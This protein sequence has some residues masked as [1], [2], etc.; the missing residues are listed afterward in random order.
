MCNKF[1]FEFQ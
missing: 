1:L